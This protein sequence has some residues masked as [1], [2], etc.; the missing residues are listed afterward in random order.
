MLCFFNPLQRVVRE[1]VRE[2]KKPKLT[3][4]PGFRALKKGKYIERI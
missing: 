1:P 2:K 4:G 3:A